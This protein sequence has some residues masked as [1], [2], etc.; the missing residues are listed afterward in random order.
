MELSA[1]LQEKQI[2]LVVNIYSSKSFMSSQQTS[3]ILYSAFCRGC[4]CILYSSSLYTVFPITWSPWLGK[5]R[6]PRLRTVPS[7]SEYAQRSSIM[8]VRQFSRAFCKD[9]RNGFVRTISDFTAPTDLSLT[10]WGSCDEP[11][12]NSTWSER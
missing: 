10:E 5:G 12:K 2:S 6:S 11:S 7:E 1:K 3:C 8:P 9:Q 4:L